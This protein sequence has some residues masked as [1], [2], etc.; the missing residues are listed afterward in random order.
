[1]SIPLPSFNDL[2]MNY[3]VSSSELVKSNI[4]GNVN[5]A[6]IT[7]TCVVRM[8]RAFNYVGVDHAVFATI[9]P[10]WKTPKHPNFL[11]QRKL[12]GHEIP[13]NYNYIKAFVTVSGN[14]KKRYAIRVDE[15]LDY[16]NHKYRL[17]NQHVKL[18]KD[19]IVMADQMRAFKKDI[20]R[21]KGMICFKV[22]FQDATGH[23]TLWDG[24][25]CLHGNYLDDFRLKEVFFWECR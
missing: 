2:K 25:D 19:F 18:D 11:E 23:F 10:D 1:M 4:G 13:T 5:A 14:D 6:Y 17:C 12:N 16:I 15:F 21:K 22:D 7:N 3:P 24:S 8:C 20:S 9:S